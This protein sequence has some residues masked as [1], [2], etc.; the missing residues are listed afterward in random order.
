LNS[1]SSAA[2]LVGAPTADR[3]STATRASSVRG[4]SAADA[5]GARDAAA[6][7][8]FWLVLMVMTQP[9]IF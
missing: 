6:P 5:R 3:N 1:S 7:A 4:T 9:I 8:F 2:Q